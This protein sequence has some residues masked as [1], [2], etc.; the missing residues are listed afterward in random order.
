MAMLE[1]LNL[2]AQLCFSNLEVEYDSSTVFSW[3]N[4]SSFVRWDFTYL[5][6]RAQA[7]DSSSS[8]II[9]HVF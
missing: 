5:V 8:I 1:G 2:A 9:I 3:A 6:G 4:S 7:L